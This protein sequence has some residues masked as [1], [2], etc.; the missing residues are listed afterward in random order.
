M[1]EADQI[2][3][4]EHL[5]S[6]KQAQTYLQNAMNS[7]TQAEAM[8]NNLAIHQTEQHAQKAK[9]VLYQSKINQ[10]P[11]IQTAE[12]DIEQAEKVI[13]QLKSSK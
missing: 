13:Q 8:Q 12:Q 1:N 4:K 11:L 3:S 7:I 6:L 5:K 10:D 9:Q 2:Q